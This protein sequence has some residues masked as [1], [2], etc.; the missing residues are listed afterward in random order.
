MH[1]KHLFTLL[2]FAATASHA[3]TGST[4]DAETQFAQI[5]SWEGRWSVAETEALEIVFEPTARGHTVVERWETAAGLHSMTVYHLDGDHVVATHY[6][7]QGNQ[8]RLESLPATPDRI[9]FAF[10]DVT[11]FDEG[12]SHAHSLAFDL[13]EDGMIGR[14][15]IY[16]GPDGPGE[17]GRYTLKRVIATESE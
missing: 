7:P 11:G 6:C 13:R 8:P 1:G 4:S 16:H 9:A 14:T 3:E 5:L 15:E 17:P 2:V 12:E 10:R